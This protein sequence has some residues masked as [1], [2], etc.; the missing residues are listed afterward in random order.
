MS[1]NYKG[2]LNVSQQI[3][4]MAN[5]STNFVPCITPAAALFNMEKQRLL[6]GRDMILSNF[7]HV[8]SSESKHIHDWKV[9]RS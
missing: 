1:A 3:D 7:V 6:T 2:T 4:R 8:M 9:W 5:Q